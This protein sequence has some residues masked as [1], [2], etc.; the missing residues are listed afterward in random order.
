MKKHILK[1]IYQHKSNLITN[2]QFHKI[3]WI[4]KIKRNGVI[5]FFHSTKSQLLENLFAFNNSVVISSVF[6]SYKNGGPKII[7]NSERSHTFPL[8]LRATF[9]SNKTL[10]EGA[11]YKTWIEVYYQGLT[12]DSNLGS[13]TNVSSRWSITSVKKYCWQIG[14]FPLF[15]VKFGQIY[16][17]LKKW[18][19]FLST[20]FFEWVRNLE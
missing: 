10:R 7:H 17:A 6:S 4:C 14:F 16:F 2:L 15:Y 8:C 3:K 11:S 9:F 20:T 13:D 1:R 5:A 12:Q 19:L 18:T